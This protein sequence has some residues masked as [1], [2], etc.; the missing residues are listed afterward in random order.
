MEI[1]LETSN[2][3]AAEEKIEPEFLQDVRYESAGTYNESML[4]D[5]F[6]HDDTMEFH[7]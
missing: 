3:T 6:G 1:T 4:S 2:T 5:Q 7:L